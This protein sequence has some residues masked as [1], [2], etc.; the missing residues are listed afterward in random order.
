MTYAE[1]GVDSKHVREAHKVLARRLESSFETRKGRVG[2]PLFPI[3]HY[4][5]L[6]HLGHGRVLSL[7]TDSVGTKVLVA[8]MMRKYDTIG[9]D[10]VA[11]CVNDLVCTGSEPISFLDYMAMSKPDRNIVEEV[12]VG[13]VKGAREAEI[14]I[15]GGET[16]IVP[17]L[18]SEKGRFD[19][20]GFAAGFCM[21]EDLILGDRVVAGD[22][23][24]GVSSSGIHS[25]GLSL[26]R[27]V[28]LKKHRLND[29]PAPLEKS[30]GEELLE[31][32]RIYVRPVRQLMGKA[33][34]HGIAHVTGGGAFLKLGRVL[35]SGTL[36]ADLDGLPEPPGIFRLIGKEGHISD[37]EMYRTF[38]MGIGLVVVS[39]RAQADRIIHAFK[40]HR[41]E[42]MRIGTVQKKAGIRI[43]GKSL[44]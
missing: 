5:G 8:Q 40:K 27:R 23:L 2:W 19:L 29:T 25:N 37:G 26:A 3:G 14:A 24:I 18:L 17:E 21:R 9:I 32:T 4:A 44:N 31:P 34:I 12:A 15:V 43:K 16:A 11:M 13:L 33:E 6:V 30:V 1:A 28:L 10:C 20:V 39:P 38:N 35:R 36:G 42:A 7:H 41:Q 22:V